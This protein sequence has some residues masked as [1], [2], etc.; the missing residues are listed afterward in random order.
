MKGSSGENRNITYMMNT[1]VEVKPIRTMLF[2]KF[3]AAEEC[4]INT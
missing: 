1:F 3:W 4:I 2:Y